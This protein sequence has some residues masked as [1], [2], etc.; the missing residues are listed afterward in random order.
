[1]SPTIPSHSKTSDSRS[2]GEQVKSGLVI[3]G[4]FVVGFLTF[5]M[6]SVGIVGLYQQAPSHFLGPLTAWFELCVATVI[7]FATAERWG[8]YIPGFFLIRGFIGG[9]IH[10]IYP[11]PP[12]VH[13]EGL[14]RLEGAGLAIYSIALLAVL[15]RFIPPRR[16]RAT[17]V[18]RTALTIFALSVASM[19]ALPPGTF[20]RAPLVGSIP[21]LIAWTVYRW[22]L[23]RHGRKPS[24]HQVSPNVPVSRVER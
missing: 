22:K 17:V 23:S 20:L 21:L 6:A 11:S 10:T 9:I 19:L 4:E 3:A 16:V 18:D 5:L 7:I 13:S 24:H 8:G 15:W 12:G 14:T 2:V 1:V